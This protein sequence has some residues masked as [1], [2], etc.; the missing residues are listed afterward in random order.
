MAAFP[1]MHEY[2]SDL[3]LRLIR[4]AQARGVEMEAPGF[5]PRVATEVLELAGTVAHTSERKFA[6]LA[7][8]VTGL[9]VGKLRAAGELGSDS[10]IAASSLS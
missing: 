9:A 10:E 3:G 7:S 8:F 5:D 2:V 6:P 1:H 4:L